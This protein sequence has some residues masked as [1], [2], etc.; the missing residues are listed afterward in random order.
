MPK[1]LEKG[2]AIWRGLDVELAQFAVHVQGVIK[3][4]LILR[5]CEQAG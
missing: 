1:N 5:S 3:G 4:L 2:A